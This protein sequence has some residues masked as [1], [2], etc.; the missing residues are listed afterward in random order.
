MKIVITNG[1]WIVEEALAVMGQVGQIVA[2][3]DH[4]E[5]VLFNEMRDADVIVV[6]FSPHVDR[7][8]IESSGRLRHIARLGVGVESVDLLAA[9]ERGIIVTNTPDLTA[10]SVAEFTM[11]LLLSLAKN[12]PSC[13]RAVREGRW[14]ERLGLIRLN[15]ELCGKT[16]GIVGMGAIGGRVAVRCKAFG[17]RVIY[18]KRNR[19]LEFERKAGVEY[20]P[21]ETLIKESDSISLHVPLTNETRNLF[22]GPRFAS[23]KKDALLIN[24]ARGKVVNEEALV[25]ALREGRIGGYATDVYEHEPPDPTCELLGLKNVVV[26]PHVGGGTREARLRACTALAEDI[27]KVSRGEIPKHLVNREVLQKRGL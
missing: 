18:N 12:L 27:V 9:T 24:Q 20:V 4:S 25:Q 13:D 5:E 2:P 8:L 15:R 14:E 1:L 10:D 23:M 22:D 26:A 17:M 6:S 7:R 3:L 11:T 21:F 19:D 16:H